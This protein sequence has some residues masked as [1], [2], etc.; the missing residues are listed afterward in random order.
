MN[1]GFNIPTAQTAIFVLFLSVGVLFDGAFSL[2]VSLNK[3]RNLFK[4]W[5][6]N[7]WRIS[8]K[9][10]M[11]V[12]NITKAATFKSFLRLSYKN[13][14]NFFVTVLFNIFHEA[15]INQWFFGFAQKYELRVFFKIQFLSKIIELNQQF[16]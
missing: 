4:K 16:P 14:I 1:N 5:P 7:P 6:F 2:W 12:G 10:M 8:N 13:T 15:N 11:Q 3:T 9:T